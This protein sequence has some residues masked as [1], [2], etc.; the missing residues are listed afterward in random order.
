MYEEIVEFERL[1]DLIGWDDKL[2]ISILLQFIYFMKKSKL[3]K[4]YFFA[5]IPYGFQGYYPVI[6]VRYL[7]SEISKIGDLMISEFEDFHTNLTC[8]EM[9]DFM[10]NMKN[11]I[12]AVSDEI[13]K[14]NIT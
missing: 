14:L 7:N 11:E 2:L 6:G 9:L 10:L 13:D 12:N 1:D 4:N 5:V 8:K 3:T